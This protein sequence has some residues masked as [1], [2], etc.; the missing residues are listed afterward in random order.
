MPNLHALHK[1]L[2]SQIQGVTPGL[3]LRAYKKGKCV[4]DL[5]VGEVFPYYDLASL[6]KVVFTMSIFMRAL[7]QKRIDLQ[8]LQEPVQ[9]VLP[10]FQFRNIIVQNLLTH[11]SGLNAWLP[12]Y[13]KTPLKKTRTERWEN[14]K[15]LINASS[16]EKTSQAVYSDVGIL[17]LGHWLE[18]VLQ[19]PLLDLWSDWA[20]EM[21]FQNLHFHENNVPIYKKT[22]YAPTEDCSWRKKILQGEVHDDNT[23]ALG[24]VA[25]H[26]G[27]F[28][29]LDDL[30]IWAQHLRKSFYGQGKT[31]IDS[32]VTRLFCSRAISKEEGDWGLG[33]MMPTS[34]SASCGQYF[35]E[36]SFGHT[37]FTGTSFWFDPK[38][39]FMVILLSN[40]VHPT[41]ANRKFIELRPQ[42]HNQLYEHLI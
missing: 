35:H 21:G 5:Q 40:R 22:L 27:L 24:G 7:T 18:R 3:V 23:W 30:E 20:T 29:G 6:T 36:T 16:Y 4:A 39:D 13:K 37:G 33:F 31:L 10:W 1:Q 11:T 41:R 14:L 25:S 42:I 19:K 9:K 12:F 26:A 32:K 2:Q 15:I 38:A 17:T 28:G 34:G 8:Q